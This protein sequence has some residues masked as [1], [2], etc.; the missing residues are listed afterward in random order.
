MEANGAMISATM[1]MGRHGCPT[2]LTLK[3][4]I[5]DGKLHVQR[6]VIHAP[7]DKSYEA[8]QGRLLPTLVIFAFVLG[9]LYAAFLLVQG[10]ILQGEVKHT[11]KVTTEL[12][13][14]ITELEDE[15]IAELYT[16]ELLKEKIEA[17]RTTWSQLVAKVQELTPVTVFYSTFSG[18]ELGQIQ[19]NGYGDSY[20][21]VADAIKE[22]NRSNEFTNVFV[23]AVS[24][25]TA[26]D[27]QGIA[28]FSVS[29]DFLGNDTK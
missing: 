24:L 12:Q 1:R 9:L 20:E 17:S 6:I 21:A 4:L 2:V 26:A 23:P 11:Q 13:G 3:T 27:G 16:A 29:F 8:P 5:D 10:F 28:S 22:L 7:M 15:Q 19:L 18:G 25:G 14:K